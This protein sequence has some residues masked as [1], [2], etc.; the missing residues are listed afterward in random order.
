[1][2]IVRNSAPRAGRIFAALGVLTASVA[3]A[4][5]PALVS[6]DTI[7]T[8]SVTLG[9]SAKSNTNTSYEVKFTPQSTAGTTGAFLIDFCTTAA[10]GAAC[11]TPTGLDVTTPTTTGTDT[12][13]GLDA[14]TV[15]VVLTTPV[16]AAGNVDV[17]LGGLTNPSTVGAMYARIVTYAD[18]AAAGTTN[19]SETPGT[20]YDDGSVALDI[21]DGFSVNGSVLESL[22]FC[23]TGDEALTGGTT[24]TDC[25][26]H[27]V[28]PNI[29]LGTSGVLDEA[30]G[31]D[32]DV[33]T[34]LSTNA[35]GG[36]VVNLKSDAANCGGLYR[37]GVSNS[38]NCGI[39]PIGGGTA[40]A[41]LTNGAAK[42]G[43][44]L[45][46][47]QPVG[48]GALASAGT[49]S[50]SNYNMPYDNTHGGLLDDVTSVYGAPVYDTSGAPTNLGGGKLSFN[51]NRSSL[52]PAGNYTA[53]FSLI[54]T[55]TF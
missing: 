12:V 55:G 45:T 46:L 11:V 5:L 30:A 38:T 48:G 44:K 8:R 16:A 35:S 40:A 15:K 27:Q 14:N 32:G 2:D 26:S 20:H 34:F 21:T 50:S 51:A 24:A 39:G 49:W 47:S 19:D 6:A 41:A 13:T 36:A 4:A 42:F 10:V 28:A 43:A 54:A 25:A 29:K 9:S 7:T 52:T 37:D 31:T 18:S 22:T 23:A 53:K 3:S 17:V 1:M 33:L